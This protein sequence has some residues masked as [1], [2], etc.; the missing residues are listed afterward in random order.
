MDGW[1]MT[2]SFAEIWV[3]RISVEQRTEQAW[4]EVRRWGALMT[5]VGKNVGVCGGKGA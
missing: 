1:R 2:G 4:R 5:A 3:V